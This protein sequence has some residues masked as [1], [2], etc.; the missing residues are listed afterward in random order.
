MPLI[1]YSAHPPQC[2][3]YASAYTSN[4]GIYLRVTDPG[5]GAWC[6]TRALPLHFKYVCTTSALYNCMHVSRNV[7]A[8][9][10]IT[11]FLGLSPTTETL[12]PIGLDVDPL[13]SYPDPQSHSCG[14][15]TSPLRER[16]SGELFGSDLF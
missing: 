7:Q 5:V 2:G 8:I 9:Q 16:G 15:I 13:V 10:T 4:L 14:W 11:A 3:V 12:G 6:G 1:S